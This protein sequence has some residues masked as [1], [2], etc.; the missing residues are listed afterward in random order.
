MHT[1][2]A[3][4]NIKL[5][6]CAHSLL[7]RQQS[8]QFQTRTCENKKINNFNMATIAPALTLGAL[9]RDPAAN[10]WDNRY[11]SSCGVPDDLCPVLSGGFPSHGSRVGSGNLNGFYRAHPGS[12]HHGGGFRIQYRPSQGHSRVCPIRKSGGS[13]QRGPW[14]NFL[15]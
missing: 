10:L 14:C 12:G 8:K 13:S 9:F 7:I 15:L 4:E 2:A 5:R 1:G 3:S 6:R 11:G